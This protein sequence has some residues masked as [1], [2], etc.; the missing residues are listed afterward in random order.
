MLTQLPPEL[1]EAAT[2]AGNEGLRV[3]DPSTS[4]VYRIV[5]EQA[6]LSQRDD[7]D[8]NAIAEGLS[9]MQAGLGKT[10][11]QA[12]GDIAARLAFPKQP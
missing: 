7:H 1:A 5:D 9:Q 6:Y 3:I 10:A 8:R 4:R 11:D 2:S 12:F